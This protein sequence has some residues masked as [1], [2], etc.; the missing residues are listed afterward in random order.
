[1]RQLHCWWMFP[2]IWEDDTY[3]SERP[4]EMAAIRNVRAQAFK[5]QGLRYVIYLDNTYGR[6]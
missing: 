6:D 2:D 3:D 4:T 1:M 5:A